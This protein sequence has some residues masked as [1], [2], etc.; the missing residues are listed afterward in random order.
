MKTIGKLLLKWL[1]TFIS[2]HL[3]IFGLSLSNSLAFG[4]AGFG[5]LF[6]LSI[7]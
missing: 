5:L 7:N 4:L 1:L 2:S 6:I 3:V